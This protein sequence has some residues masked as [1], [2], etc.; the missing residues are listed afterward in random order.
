MAIH[1]NLNSNLSK[2]VS[3]DC[4]ATTFDVGFKWRLVFVLATANDK[5]LG[6]LYDRETGVAFSWAYNGVWFIN[7][8]ITEVSDTEFSLSITTG[9]WYCYG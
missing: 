4:S 5:P 3:G 6:S 2:F 7:Q 9:K 1:D 8:H